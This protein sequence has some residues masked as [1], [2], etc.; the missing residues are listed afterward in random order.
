LLRSFLRRAIHAGYFP[1]AS[2]G[3]S[4]DGK[5]AEIISLGLRGIPGGKPIDEKTVFDLASLTKPLVVTTLLLR[6]RHDFSLNFDL[7]LGEFFPRLHSSWLAHITIIE[8]LTHSSGL[9]AWRPLY[10]MQHRGEDIISLIGNL[11]TEAAPGER[12]IYSCLGYILL[13]RL[14]EKLYQSPLDQIFDREV[15]RKL[16]LKGRL[17]FHPEGPNLA[18]EPAWPGVEA[19]LT[20]ELGLDPDSLPPGGRPEDGNARFLGGVAGNAGLFGT[21]SAVLSLAAE[22]LP[23]GGTLLGSKDVEI[24]TMRRPLPEDRRLGWQGADAPSS[25]AGPAL[26]SAAFG[27]TG[28]S[29]ASLWIDPISKLIVLLLCHRNHPGYRGVDLHPLRR[30]FHQLVMRFSS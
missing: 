30:R 22:Y 23:G 15:V 17:G 13:G 24:A 11:K 10:A 28:F 6:A 5:I 19:K 21:V 16:R 1:G 29:G 7:E 4:I 14:L 9:P 18:F 3:W 27:H 12:I 26:S 2:A 20:C 8:L 25:S